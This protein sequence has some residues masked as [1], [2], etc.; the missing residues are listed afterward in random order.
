MTTLLAHVAPALIGTL[1]AAIVAD[2]I[3]HNGLYA[4]VVGIGLLL[5]LGQWYV[6]NAA[7]RRRH[8]TIPRTEER[9]REIQITGSL[10]GPGPDGFKLFF[11]EEAHGELL[12]GTTVEVTPD[13]ARQLWGKLGQALEAFDERAGEPSSAERR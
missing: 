5:G 3:E 9:M 1:V 4:V 2:L 13:E 6:W 10:G 8:A 11:P 12:L 7:R